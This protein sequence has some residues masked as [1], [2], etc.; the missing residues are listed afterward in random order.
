M[1]HKLA[2]S[3]AQLKVILND[4][5]LDQ[6]LKSLNTQEFIKELLV[7]LKD[8][9]EFTEKR[10]GMIGLAFSHCDSK[11]REFIIFLAFISNIA[12]WK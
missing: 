10:L 2:K 8:D 12:P 9:Y 7:D 6:H 5:S 1:T 11:N 3:L 4:L